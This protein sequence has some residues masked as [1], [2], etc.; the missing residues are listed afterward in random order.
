VEESY[1]QYGE[2]VLLAKIFGR[3]KTGVCL[4]VGAHDGISLSNTF[5]FEQRGWSCILVEPNPLLCEAIIN[6]RTTRPFRCA[7]SDKCG[8]T[9]LYLGVG[10]DGLS[11][12][13]SG[14]SARDRLDRESE[15]IRC[16][17]VQTRTL[18]DIL[19]E[20]GYARI[21][22]ISIDVE[23]HEASVLRG[24]DLGRWK[25]KILIV[26]NNS[27]TEDEDV[28]ALTSRGGYRRV[29][30][31]GCNN[32]YAR[33]EDSEVSGFIKVLMISGDPL[34]GR[35]IKMIAKAIL[36]KRLLPLLR[37]LR[38]SGAKRPGRSH[39]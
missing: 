26:E 11:T 3:V 4:E 14:G 31:T 9:I 33:R 7:A 22:F 16:V 13:E 36:P 2:D 18:D 27:E 23:G 8:T 1:S 20:T 25:P 30:R 32:W 38:R 5:L 19:A 37:R 21:D 10:A 39:S 6:N 28:R 35:N 17:E 15:E 29:F 34:A 24:L 12:I